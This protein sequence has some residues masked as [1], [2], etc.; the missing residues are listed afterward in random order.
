[1]FDFDWF[2]DF[3]IEDWMIHGG[4]CEDFADDEKQRREIEQ[5][6]FGDS[7]DQDEDYS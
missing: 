7:L 2:D 6:N 5:D 1:M 4:L 3:G